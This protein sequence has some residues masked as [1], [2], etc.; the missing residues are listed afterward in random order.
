MIDFA[1]NFVRTLYELHKQ[2]A[3]GTL[4]CSS[5]KRETTIHF[6]NGKILAVNPVKGF[7]DLAKYL[8]RNNILTQ[9]QLDLA[10]NWSGG[11][12]SIERA[13]AETDA[14]PPSKLVHLRMRYQQSILASVVHWKNG[15]ILFS[16]VELERSIC[17]DNQLF[18]HQA[19]PK[20]LWALISNSFQTGDLLP[21]LLEKKHGDF[22]FLPGSADQIKQFSF[23]KHI[24]KMVSLQG[25]TLSL[26]KITSLIVDTTGELLQGLWLLTILGVVRRENVQYAPVHLQEE[27]RKVPANPPRQASVQ[28]Q[29]K[30]NRYIVTVHKDYRRLMNTN[31]YAFLKLPEHAPQKEIE[32]RCSNRKRMLLHLR[33]TIPNLDVDTTR[34]IDDL[35][36]AID[37]VLS[38]LGDSQRRREYDRKLQFGNAPLITSKGSRKESDQ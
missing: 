4:L 23:S 36:Y 9:G 18:I 10:Y 38:H 5:L 16:R 30:A 22:V 14:L 27:V 12:H 15:K 20:L 7:G 19:T 37:T 2:G 25:N 26:Q 33:K 29:E 24:E 31:Y 1:E 34:M 8:Q 13:L 28:K 21:E 32:E 17:M 35:L 6:V 3:T 11:K